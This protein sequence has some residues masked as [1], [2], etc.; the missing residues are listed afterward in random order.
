MARSNELSTHFALPL[1]VQAFEEHDRIRP[2]LD[3]ISQDPNEGDMRIFAWGNSNYTSANF[4]RFIFARA[5]VDK[6]IDLIWKSKCLPKLRI[7]LW[8]LV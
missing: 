6:A 5:P 7:F 2:H 3:S 1:S 4:Y 8:L